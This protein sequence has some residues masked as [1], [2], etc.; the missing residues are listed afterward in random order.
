MGSWLGCRLLLSENFSNL[1]VIPVSKSSLD[2]SKQCFSTNTRSLHA[3]VTMVACSNYTWTKIISNSFVHMFTCYWKQW[4]V[5]CCQPPWAPPPRARGPSHLT[6]HALVQNVD[7]L[8]TPPLLDLRS[9]LFLSSCRLCMC[10]YMTL[11]QTLWPEQKLEL[12]RRK[13]LQPMGIVGRGG[14][15]REEEGRGEEGRGEEGREEW[16]S[17]SCVNSQLT[18]GVQ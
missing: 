6:S 11:Y 5:G 8:W 18:Y 2:S 7:F 1:L 17:K 12:Q 3:L 4:L 15:G 13:T 16:Q 14:E 10:I 9:L